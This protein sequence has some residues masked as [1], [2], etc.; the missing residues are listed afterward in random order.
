MRR[1]LS[2]CILAA[3]CLA[4]GGTFEAAVLEDVHA[5]VNLSY[6]VTDKFTIGPRDDDEAIQY[7]DFGALMYG[8][9]N[10]RRTRTGGEIGDF[11]FLGV[12]IG[13]TYW[14]LPQTS[15]V[16][17][18][19][20]G[21]SAYGISVGELDAYDPNVESGGRVS[22]VGTWARVELVYVDGPGQFSVWQNAAGGPKVMMATSNGIQPDDS[23]WSLAGGH[24]HQNWGFSAAGS[25]DVQM[26]AFGFFQDG[27]AGLG[28]VERGRLFTLHFGLEEHPAIIYGDV[29]LEAWQGDVETIPIEATLTLQGGT[30]KK[31]TQFIQRPNISNLPNTKGRF[32]FGFSGVGP[33]TLVVKPRGYLSRK[34]DLDLGTISSSGAVVKTFYSHPGNDPLSLQFLAGDCDND[35]FITTDDYLILSDSFDTSTG[36][37]GFDARADIDGNGSITTDDYLILSTNFDL[38]GEGV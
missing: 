35:D 36:D 13:Q 31:K 23:Y 18:I 12:G 7:D 24:G 21:Y 29:D 34:V 32:A 37:P 19:F 9:T 14:R 10:A 28:P 25:Y 15:A 3:G 20:L 27:L 2:L 1:T 17:L 11:S 5:D 30:A 33:A 16:G 26:R 22:G 4:W 8:G 6:D 38:S